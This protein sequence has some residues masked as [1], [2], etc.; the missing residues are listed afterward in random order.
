MY[1]IAVC[2]DDKEFRYK[3]IK[4]IN[5]LEMINDEMIFFEFDTGEQLLQTNEKYDVLF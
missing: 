2:D 1:K 3:V 4:M 5:D